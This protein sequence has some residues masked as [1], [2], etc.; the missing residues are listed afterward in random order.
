M[1]FSL[2][3]E[4]LPIILIVASFVASCYFYAHFPARVPSHWNFKG[5]I[6]N[7]SS[8]AVGAF[9]IPLLILAMY[10]LFLILPKIDPKKE[11]YD[12]FARVYHIF[13]LAIILV[14]LLLYFV[15]GLA[16]LGHQF[17]VGK[18]V[19]AVIG[20][21]FIVLGNYM[22]KL[23]PNW[24]MGIR[25]PWTMSSETVWQKTHRLGGWMFVLAGLFL[26]SG[27]FLA[28]LHVYPVLFVIV[29]AAVLLVPVVYSYLLYREERRNIDKSC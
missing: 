9:A 29:I 6:D 14:L 2:K 21:L 17:E 1:K 12:R 8:R 23:K 5:E 27:A 4:I 20:I 13:K 11:K 18:I 24:F 19:P 26:F 15:T 28:K 7:Y 22:G 16:G 25:T 3:T 10:L